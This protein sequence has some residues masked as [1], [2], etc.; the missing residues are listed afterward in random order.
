MF[1]AGERALG[2]FVAKL[3]LLLLVAATAAPCADNP[4][5]VVAKQPSVTSVI[6]VTRDGVIK[7]NLLSDETNL[8]VTE[9]PAARHVV[10]RVSL[11]D[12]SRSVISNAFPNVQALDLS[13]D[14]STLLVSPIKGGGDTEFSTLPVKSGAPKRVGDLTGRD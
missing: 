5:E 2:P 4:K 14:R 9:S 3:G 13:P 6:Q 12:V 8:Y 10:A 1:T 7:T 11:P